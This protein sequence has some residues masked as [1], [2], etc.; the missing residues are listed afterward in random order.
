L[1]ASVT[2][3]ITAHSENIGSVSN[4]SKQIIFGKRLP[5]LRLLLYSVRIQIKYKVKVKVKQCRYRPVEAQR[6]PGS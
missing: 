4:K 1:H 2:E 6:V 3:R 5:K